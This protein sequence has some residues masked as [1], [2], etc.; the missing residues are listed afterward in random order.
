MGT[1]G[2]SILSRFMRL[3]EEERESFS[4]AFHS[5]D[6]DRRSRARN[7]K[8]TAAHVEEHRNHGTI[9]GRQSLVERTQSTI[10]LSLG[11]QWL[12]VALK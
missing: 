5:D 8:A 6:S 11:R 10:L 12:A 1:L 4:I 7:Q 3:S 2:T 9:L